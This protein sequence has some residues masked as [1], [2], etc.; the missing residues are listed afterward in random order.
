MTEEFN[1]AREAL[2]AT[3]LELLGRAN[4]VAAGV[5]YKITKGEK[6]PALSVICSV[7]KKVKIADLSP[8]DRVPETMDGIPTDVVQSGRFHVFAHTNRYRPAPGGVS[9][10]HRDITAG[11]LGCLV[12]KNGVIHILSNNHVLAN[13]NDASVGDAILQPG[14]VDGGKYPDDHIANLTDFV[15]I[16]FLDSSPSGCS[17]ANG[18]ASFLNGIASAMGSDARLQAITTQATDNL[19]DAAIARPL[20]DSDVSEDILDIGTIAGTASGELDMAI[21]KSGRTTEF[22][23]GVIEQVDVTVDVSYGTG[24]TARFTD[25][26]I[27]GAMSQGGDSGSS[28]LDNNNRL[29]GLLFAGSDQSTIINRIEN[30]FSALNISL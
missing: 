16:S 17:L 12:R 19:V 26:L 15:P 29:V 4:V 10:G 6:T 18:V 27:A 20:S 14:P 1:K 25:Q 30:V 5:G 13:S 9:I 24:R 2:K 8:K 22:T 23:T 21:K 7:A 28:V 11:T 3:R